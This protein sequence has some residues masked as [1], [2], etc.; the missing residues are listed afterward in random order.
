MITYVFYQ[1]TSQSGSAV[2]SGSFA[3]DSA[4]IGY[5]PQLPEGVY[6]IE[7]QIAVDASTAYTSVIYGP[8]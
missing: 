3:D 1:W 7:K 2:Y 5:I 4:A 8:M 6:S